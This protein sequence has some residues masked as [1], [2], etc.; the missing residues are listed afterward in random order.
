MMKHRTY[1]FAMT[2]FAVL[3]TGCGTAPIQEGSA[4]S[5][6]VDA[7]QPDTVETIPADELETF[8]G[9]QGLRLPGNLAAA[10]ATGDDYEEMTEITSFYGTSEQAWQRLLDGELDAVLAYA[11]D[12]ETKQKLEEQ[13][14]LMQPIGSDAL[15][16]LANGEQQSVTLTKEEIAAA[17]QGSSESWTGYAAA[18][19]ADS[20]KLFAE[21]F[22]VDSTG[23]Q[24]QQGEEMLTAACPHTEGTLCYTTYLEMQENGIPQN[25][26]VVTVDDSLPGSTSYPLNTTYYLACRGGLEDNAPIMQFYRWLTSEDGTGWLAQ[27]VAPPEDVPAA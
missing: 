8:G 25:T 15:V 26:T 17:Y 27:A 5:A 4:G 13:G 24:I 1:L 7:A 3:L 6:S 19:G 14:V 11:P 20:R 16:F 21:L 23:V 2:L 9:C 12:S 22:G 10:A 18:P